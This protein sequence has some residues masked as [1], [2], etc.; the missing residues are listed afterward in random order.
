MPY[1][2]RCRVRTFDSRRAKRMRLVKH[3]WA[4]SLILAVCPAR[5]QT[6]PAIEGLRCEYL[7][8]P[9]GIDVEKP[10][11][12]WISIQGA[13]GWRQTA[14]RILAA[15]TPENLQK[16]TGD[17]WDSGKVNSDRS[18]W[19]AYAGKPLTSGLQVYSKVRVWDGA[20]RQLPW[21]GQAMWSMGLLRPADWRARWIGAAR[22]QGA[23][24]GEAAPV[25]R[26]RETFELAG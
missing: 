8:N 2:P 19:V 21:S 3:A 13:R 12:S 25:P 11:L 26:P 16:D 24:G 14:Y 1:S 4:L 15:S 17:L 5:A 9:L 22:P 20:N 23:G 6:S 18:T 7:T 10:R